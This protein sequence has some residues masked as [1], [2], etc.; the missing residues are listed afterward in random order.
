MI[1]IFKIA[2]SVNTMAGGYLNVNKDNIGAL[3]F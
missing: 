2:N 1:F 3:P